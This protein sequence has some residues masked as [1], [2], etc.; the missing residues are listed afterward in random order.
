MKRAWKLEVGVA[1]GLPVYPGF[2]PKATVRNSSYTQWV[3]DA[4]TNQISIINYFRFLSHVV[5]GVV[6]P[7]C[8]TRPRHDILL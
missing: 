5:T 4:S 6:P 8:I 1:S 2:V 3:R 7:L